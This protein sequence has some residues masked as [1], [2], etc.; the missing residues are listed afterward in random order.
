MKLRSRMVLTIVLALSVTTA[1]ASADDALLNGFRDPPSGARPRVWWHWMNGNVTKEGI[2]LDLEWMKRIGLGGAENFQ[3]FMGP[4]GPGQVVGKRLAYMSPEWRDA[5]HHAAATADKLDLELGI[6]ASPGW[7]E[8]GGPWVPLAHGMKKFVW[9][10]T[11]VTGGA[12]FHAALPEPPNVV[13]PYQSL[14]LEGFQSGQ[15]GPSIKNARFYV[16]S[17]VVA[18]PAPEGDA[19][20]TEQNASVTASAGHIDRAALS[21][22]TLSHPQ[23]LPMAPPGQSAWVEFEYPAPVTI[24]A[25]TVMIGG[26][27]SLPGFGTAPP[28]IGLE[29][30]QDG[31]SFTQVLAPKVLRVPAFGTQPIP[32]T[33]AVPPTKAKHFRIIFVTPQPQPPMPAIYG[34]AAPPA[35]SWSIPQLALHVDPRVDRVEDKAGFVPA[36]GLD[37]DPTPD[38]KIAIPKQDVI[39][40]TAKMRPDGT[41]DWTPPPGRWIVL[42]IGYSL[43]GITNHPAPLE[44][45]GLEVDKFNGAYVK[46]Y[47]DRYL[48]QYEEVTMGLM[49][50]HG[51]RAITNDSWEDGS[52]NWT[53]DMLAQFQKRRGYDPR[54]WLPVLTG[55]IVQSASASDKFLWD[56][57]ET[58]ADLVADEHYDQIETEIKA[59]GLIHY[60][61]AHEEGRVFVGDG[62]AVKRRDDVPMGAMWTQAPGVY[63]EQYGYD[64]DIRESASVAHIYGQNLVAAESMTSNGPAWGWSPETLKPIVDQEFAMGVNRVIIHTSVHQPLVDKAPGLALG[65]FGQWFTR[66]ETWAEEAKPWIDYIARSDFLLQ[67]GRFVADVLYFYGEGSNITAIFGDH[68]PPIPAGYNFDYVN[69]DALIHELSVK[70]GKVVTRSGMSYRVI[71]LDPRTAHMSVALLRALRDLVRGGA[72]VVG[73]KPTDT[74][75]LADDSAEFRRLADEVWG[76]GDGLHA[77]GRGRA[78]G[79]TSIA[80]A[81]K[82]LNVAP[83]FEPSKPDAGLSFVHRAVEDGDIYYVDNRTDVPESL[84][85]A[86][87]VTGKEAELWHADT[88]AAEPASYKVEGDRT[89]VPLTLGPH[90]TVFVVFRKPTTLAERRLPAAS[91]TTLAEIEGP[92]T[93]SFDK[94]PCAPKPATFDRLV[95]WS[96]SADAQTK[97]FSGTATYRKTL[98]V[99]REWLKGDR[100]LLDLGSVK[101]L[102]SVSVNGKSIGMAWKAPFR[103]DATTVLRPGDNALSVQ[104]TDLWVNR[105]IG[106]Q[107]PAPKEKCAYADPQFAYR[108]DSP[109]VPAGLLGLV[110]I[111]RASDTRNR[112]MID[113]RGLK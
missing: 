48:D 17:A 35:T 81:L 54:P 4:L 43:L 34:P 100:V 29:S 97:Y 79:R 55:R 7:S 105:L 108:A 32:M 24:R 41:L 30:S 23:S 63:K 56:F 84:T 102:A 11:Y 33:V 59:R 64:A 9:S 13:G 92:W 103:L 101:N 60:G 42:R 6:A 26:I 12:P 87:R 16:D 95:S 96:D 73:D 91:E 18:Y 36:V 80:D 39:D 106:D 89:G 112:A 109:L 75:S 1:S 8:T 51:L 107:Q 52:Q 27:S 20:S 78:I 104:V 46:E 19:P 44:A 2:T 98:N 53:D 3:V 110:R 93:V 61:E 49:G 28:P 37:S 21:D 82:A 77:F 50:A 22:A 68:A 86:F 38:D 94:G 83:D 69:A 113:S 45:T 58:L 57:R 25:M 65:P 5:F 111:L 62:M 88:G 31:Q 40:L 76:N 71:A 70:D 85:A 14:P 74:P 72:V 47:L 99:P 10:E 90:E 66:N 15:V 67:Q